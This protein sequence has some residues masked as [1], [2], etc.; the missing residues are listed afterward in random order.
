MSIH[1]IHPS[2]RNST[3]SPWR[4]CPP[5]RFA[6]L[7][8]AMLE[9]GTGRQAASRR[10]RG[11]GHALRRARALRAER[12]L[13]QRCYSAAA[14]LRIRGLAIG[15]ALIPEALPVYKLSHAVPTA[16][17][18]LLTSKHKI[19]HGISADVGADAAECGI[20]EAETMYVNGEGAWHLL[21]PH[22]QAFWLLR[23]GE[24]PFTR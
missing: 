10:L 4:D 9:E 14:L 20:D 16:N 21:G 22:A 8:R 15:G 6:V 3:S 2:L 1:L 5:S 19:A 7:A 24:K 18:V 11:R 17:Q 23:R 12:R 13:R